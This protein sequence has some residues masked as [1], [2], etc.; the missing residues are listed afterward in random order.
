M[1]AVIHF[2]ALKSVSE[3]FEKPLEYYEN[4][5]GGTLTLLR[6]MA[7]QKVPYLVFSSSAT[8]YGEQEVQPGARE[9]GAA[10]LL[11]LRQD[12]GDL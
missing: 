10:A 8:V 1:E 7:L 2:A 6:V 11:A 9:R 3:S 12:K 5:V 4:N